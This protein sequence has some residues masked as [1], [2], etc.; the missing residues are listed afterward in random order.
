MVKENFLSCFEKGFKKLSAH[1]VHSPLS[2]L[3][4]KAQNFQTISKGGFV[5][6]CFILITEIHVSFVIALIELIFFKKAFLTH[7][8]PLVPFYNPG[9]R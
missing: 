2:S 1:R 3:Q 8:T 6:G 7:F 5:E 9:K 4:G